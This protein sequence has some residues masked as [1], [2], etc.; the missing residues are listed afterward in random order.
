M[1][2]FGYLLRSFGIGPRDHRYICTECAKTWDTSG[3]RPRDVFSRHMYEPPP[4]PGDKIEFHYRAV[5]VKASDG[6]RVIE[7]RCGDVKYEGRRATLEL[8]RTCGADVSGIRKLGE[9]LHHEDRRCRPS[10]YR[11]WDCGG[12]HEGDNCATLVSTPTPGRP[13]TIV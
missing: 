10:P 6:D 2:L 8:C 1:T 11:C 9:R 4:G 12:F 3:P 7:V 13:E 5:V